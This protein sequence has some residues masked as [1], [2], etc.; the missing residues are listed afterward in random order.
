MCAVI[1]DRGPGSLE[2]RIA[3]VGATQRAGDRGTDVA[4]A[5]V[6]P[7]DNLPKRE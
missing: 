7:A 5:A 4:G 6:E 1:F 2:L 3:N